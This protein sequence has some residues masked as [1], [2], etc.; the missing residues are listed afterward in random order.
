MLEKALRGGKIY[1]AWIA[2]LLAIIA[3]G[4]A[5]YSVQWERGLTI[6]GMKKE[7]SWGLYIANFTFLVGVAASAVMVVLPA[8]VYDYKK[9]KKIT[10]LGEFLAVAAIV[11]CMSFIFVDLGRPDRVFNVLL[12]PNFNSV[13]IYDMISLSGYLL[14]NLVI[15]WFVL[16]ARE[17]RGRPHWLVVLLIFVSIPWA[18]SIHTVTAYIYCGL[19]GRAFWHDALLAPRFLASAFSS[20]PSLV[21]LAAFISRKFAGFDVGRGGIQKLAEVVTFAMIVNMFFLGCELFTVYYSGSHLEHFTYLLFG[22]HGYSI[23]V[24]WIWLSIGLGIIATIML[25]FPQTRRNDKAL[26]TACSLV[27]VSIWID[28]GLGLVVPGFVPS[29]L[30]YIAEYWPTPLEALIT[31]GV[32]GVGLL[33]YT[34]LVKIAISVMGEVS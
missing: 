19:A 9:F 32:W 29:Q 6:T 20:G 25:I 21:I 3:I 31:L 22:L 2:F 16:S 34:M 7:V 33:V 30:G 18:I 28:K 5:A 14:F 15:A 17:V 27:I 10:A 12:H 1:W 26:I 4:A 13:M 8:Y 23:L 24:P 11:M